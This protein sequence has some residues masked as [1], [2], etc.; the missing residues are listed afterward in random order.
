MANRTVLEVNSAEEFRA[1]IS[2]GQP[3]VVD[4]FADWCG[5]CRALAPVVDRIASAYAADLRI[6]KV[7]IDALP[8]LA[9]RAKIREVPALH[10][11][12]EGRKV[13]VL[14][15]F[16]TDE[17]LRR[18]LER[19]SMVPGA[20]ATP[21]TPGPGS[22]PGEPPQERVPLARRLLAMLGRGTPEKSG[23]TATPAPAAP[24]PAAPSLATYGATSFRFIE[25]E[26]EL[27]AV[28][29]SSFHRPTALFLHDPWCP[30]SARAFRQ[31]EQL[32]G[33]LPAIDVSRQRQLNAVV[34]RR[35]GVRHQSPQ[36][37]VLRD[38]VATWDASHGRVTAAA[39]R[40]ALARPLAIPAAGSHE[41]N[42]P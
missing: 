36:V 32:G 18:E 42:A 14:T 19:Y 20:P 25:S 33:E 41:R 8:G 1:I 3:V 38:A 31:M 11:Y 34:E 9:E 23:P 21:K 37:I 16:R 27:N 12:R 29:D 30:I 35:T 10:F 2:S 40:E 6:V 13:A 22:A 17:A 39:V 28:I 24:A 4:Y 5:P 7:D 26:D 15:G